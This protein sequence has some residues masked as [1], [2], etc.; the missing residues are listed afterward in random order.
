M[1][2]GFETE[3]KIGNRLDSLSQQ[4]F[5]IHKI[6]SHGILTPPAYLLIRNE[7][8]QNTMGINMPWMKIDLGVKIPYD[9][10]FK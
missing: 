6:P 2:R 10:G 8:G 3:R 5:F 1:G 9:T 4:R 7:G